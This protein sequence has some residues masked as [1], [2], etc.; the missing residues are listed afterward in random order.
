MKNLHFLHS[1]LKDS[2]YAQSIVYRTLQRLKNAVHVVD[3]RQLC[4]LHHQQRIISWDQ[5]KRQCEEDK[6]KERPFRDSLDDFVELILIN[7]SNNTKASKTA[8]DDACNDGH[9]RREKLQAGADVHSIKQQRVH[10]HWYSS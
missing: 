4:R 9:Y 3:C 5:D 2:L 10:N 7:H 6:Q 1:P 8:E